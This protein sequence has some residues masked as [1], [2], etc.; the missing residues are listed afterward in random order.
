MPLAAAEGGRAC[1]NAVSASGLRIAP[2][3]HGI[4]MR[5]VVGR[6]SRWRALASIEPRDATVTALERPVR[7]NL[8]ILLV[9]MFTLSAVYSS[10][11]RRS[12]VRGLVVAATAVLALLGAIDL[13]SYSALARGSRNAVQERRDYEILD[14]AERALESLQRMESSYREFLVTGR[15]DAL[16]GY[17]SGGAAYAYSVSQLLD[18]SV[19]R[20][21]E[22]RIWKRLAER[23]DA[24][25]RE[26]VAP[27][28]HLRREV[29]AGRARSAQLVLMEGAGNSARYFD[30]MR[31]LLGSATRARRR[32]LEIEAAED[33]DVLERVRFAT[34]WGTLVLL[35][36][37]VLIATTAARLGAALVEIDDVGARAETRHAQQ[38]RQTD[39]LEEAQVELEHRV[40][41]RTVALMAAKED[42]EKANEAK[43]EFLANMSHELRTPLNSIIGFADILRKNKAN[44]FTKRDLEYLDRVQANGRNLLSLINGVLDL[45]KVETGHMELDTTSVPLFDL[46][47]E[48]LDELEPQANAR[49]VRLLLNGPATPCVIETDRAKLKQILSNLIGNAVKFSVPGGVVQVSVEVDPATGYPL[50]IAVADKGIGIPADRIEAIFEAFHQAD[51]STARQYGGTGLGLTISRSLALLLGCDIQATS[52]VGVGSTFTVRLPTVSG[53]NSDTPSFVQTVGTESTTPADTGAG[54]DRFLVLVIDDDPDARVILKAAFEEFAC[55]VVTAAGVDEGIAL[56]RSL[57]PNM[58]TLDLMMPRKN[59]WDALH[60]LQVDPVLRGIPVIVVSAVASEHRAQL[61]DTL[62][63]ID[64]PVSRIELGHAVARIKTVVS[65]RSLNALMQEAP[66]VSVALPGDATSSQGAIAVAALGTAAA[67]GRVP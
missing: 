6:W 46:A 44:S 64:K 26:A 45:S 51:N 49:Q 43:S 2:D 11:L 24:W 33:R 60:E 54:K 9:D 28:V 34:L 23:A 17:Q 25:Q 12:T 50:R 4:S 14:L 38:K 1:P 63:S 39:A 13:L 48:T 8:P 3:A 67:R 30:E 40:R 62:D 57:S 29:S 19:G 56:A 47:R 41:E 66:R 10:L 55:S 5:A 53:G 52:E 42:A 36:L 35:A 37:G 27:A 65:L 59:G 21:D 7:A 20:D 22:E 31:E 58:I 16:G 32:A 18:M 61:K 15:E